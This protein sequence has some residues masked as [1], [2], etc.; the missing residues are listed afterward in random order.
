[1]EFSGN[2]INHVPRSTRIRESR[3]L[4][5]RPLPQLPVVIGVH[6]WSD[7]KY[8]Y[9]VSSYCRVRK[10]ILTSME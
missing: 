5:Q 1:M 3:S 7:Y 10:L 4:K 2:V 8:L 6:K 9:S